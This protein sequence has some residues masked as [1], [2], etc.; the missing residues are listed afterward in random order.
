VNSNLET[1]LK[2][3]IYNLLFMQVIWPIYIGKK[4]P[5]KMALKFVTGQAISNDP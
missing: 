5:Q 4:L 3:F 1:K 2:L